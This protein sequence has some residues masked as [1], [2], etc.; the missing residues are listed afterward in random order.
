MTENQLK[1]IEQSLAGVYAD[2]GDEWVRANVTALVAEV[3]RLTERVK[4]L[5]TLVEQ[6][7]YEGSE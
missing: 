7:G 1:Q 4:E 2:T 6:I 5:E 3:R